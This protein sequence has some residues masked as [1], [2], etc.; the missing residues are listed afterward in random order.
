MSRTIL[1]L[2]AWS[3]LV[4]GLAVVLSGTS[5]A[6]VLLPGTSRVQAQDTYALTVRNGSGSGDYAPGALVHIWA[7][8]TNHGDLFRWWAGDRAAVADIYAPHTVV[9]MP[10]ADVLVRAELE[11]SA[12]WAPTTLMR[13]GVRIH[14]EVPGD[15]A[16]TGG[17]VERVVGVVF[18]AHRG[19]GEAEEWFNGDRPEQRNLTRQLVHHGYAVVAIDSLNRSSNSWDTTWPADAND[20]LAR[21]RGALEALTDEGILDAAWPRAAIG[22]SN[23]AG[24]AGLLAEAMDFDVAVLYGNGLPPALDGLMESPT[25]FVLGRQD[26]TGANERGQQSADALARRGIPTDVAWFEPQPLHPLRFWSILGTHPGHSREIYDDIASGGYLDAGGFLR[27]S[28]R[29]SDWRTAIRAAHRDKEGAIYEQ[30]QVAYADHTLSAEVFHTVTEFL[31]ARMLRHTR[32]KPTQPARAPDLVSVKGGCCD[33]PED[34]N[35]RV[36]IFADP[37]P[38]GSTFDRWV[39]ADAD[40]VRLDEPRARNTYVT[41]RASGSVSA[42]WRFAA[43]WSP[44]T[45]A[46]DGGAVHAHVP[47]DPVGIVIAL[48]GSGGSADGWVERQRSAEK[49]LLLDDA[50]ARGYAVLVPESTDRQARQWDTTSPHPGNP[51]IAHVADAIARMRALPAVPDDLPAF[52]LGMSNGGAFAS[53]LAD[54]LDLSAG[55]VYSA[56]GRRSVM[57]ETDVPY[58][59][60]FGMRD[61]RVDTMQAVQNHETLLARGIATGLFTLRATPVYAT[62]FAREPGIDN[63]TSRQVHAAMVDSGVLSPSFVPWNW[64]SG[65]PKA[66][67]WSA[68][69]P[70]QIQPLRSRV[71]EQL[72]VS[73]ADHVFFADANV[74]V[75]DFFDAARGA[76]PVATPTGA[77]SPTATVVATAVATGT[78]VTPATPETPEVTPTID[79]PDRASVYLPWARRE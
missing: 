10:A 26:T 12:V 34:W 52:A 72:D 70:A 69:L 43:G 53:I 37:D 19:S 31:D 23:G 63:A 51:D 76:G 2:A 73:W 56:G 55:A 67:D 33:G 40:A 3:G 64:L 11:D 45:I 18:L 7:N 78:P 47:A 14:V 25:L 68:E 75:L 24:F 16:A 41:L 59:F 79:A 6:G 42:T 48:H 66:W 13:D 61:S 54:A 4:I 44:Q 29:R 1:R 5:G 30:L 8:P 17:W 50:V 49:R 77:P 27:E 71:Q 20:D 74:A 9:R 32:G 39:T 22:F 46:L 36:A 60:A 57:R 65:A 62:R 28:P 21:V 15:G 38:A 58:F 35:G